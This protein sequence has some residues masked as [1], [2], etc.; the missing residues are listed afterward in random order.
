MFERKSKQTTLK[1]ALDI[2]A[3]DT[4][5]AVIGIGNELNLYFHDETDKD[6]DYMRLITSAERIMAKLDERFGGGGYDNIMVF[7]EQV[8][9]GRN[10][11]GMIT[12]L[13]MHGVLL[14]MMTMWAKGI[15]K[16]FYWNEVGVNTW[17][18]WLLKKY[19]VK[20]ASR[21]SK[22]Q[23]IATMQALKKCGL[24]ITNNNEADAVSLAL[25]TI[26]HAGP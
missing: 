18:S 14:I 7:P 3:S 19:N 9:M 24:D 2:S 15:S 6:G 1:I 8:F 23:K 22:D 17:R 16:Y 12:P 21:K 5:V 20:A 4:G 10:A 26:D 13:M 25:W 11:H